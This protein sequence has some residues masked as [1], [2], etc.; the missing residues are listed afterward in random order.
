MNRNGSLLISAR[1]NFSSKAIHIRA[2]FNGNEIQLV[3]SQRIR[4]FDFCIE[5]YEL[6]IQNDFTPRSFKITS[7]EQLPYTIA[8]LFSLNQGD[9]VTYTIHGIRNLSLNDNSLYVYFTLNKLPS[10]YPNRAVAQKI[11]RLDGLENQARLLR[12]EISVQNTGQPSLIIDTRLTLRESEVLTFV[13]IGKTNIEI[14][15]ILGIS[16]NTV[17]NHLKNIFKKLN[18]VNRAQATYLSRL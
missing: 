11:L 4:I 12:Y 2:V 15:M 7:Q 6:L 8:F 1:G 17:K 9:V 13:R 14:S 10:T 18:V 5:N 3:D 16:P